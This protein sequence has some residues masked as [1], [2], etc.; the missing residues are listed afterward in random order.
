MILQLHRLVML[1]T[2][3]LL[4]LDALRGKLAEHDKYLILCR[5]DDEVMD[6]LK[7][8][9]LVERLG[10]SNLQPDLTAALQRAE[11]I[12]AGTISR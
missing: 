11:A 5:A 10:K 6:V 7:G 8:S 2:T 4:T 1:D 9:R 12:L 3:G